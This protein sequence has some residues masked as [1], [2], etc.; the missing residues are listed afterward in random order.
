[1]FI[2]WDVSIFEIFQDR[3]PPGFRILF[4]ILITRILDT[5]YFLI[6]RLEEFH[7]RIH[8]M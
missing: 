7:H 6:L 5:C 2:L 8:D 4:R 1:M 3:D